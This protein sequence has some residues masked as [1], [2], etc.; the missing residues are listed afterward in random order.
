MRKTSGLFRTAVIDKVFLFLLLLVASPDGAGALGLLK[1]GLAYGNQVDFVQPTYL[2]NHVTDRNYSHVNVSVNSS[3][4]NLTAFIDWNRSLVGWWAFNGNVSLTQLV[5]DSSTYGNNGTLG[6]NTSVEAADPAWTAAGVFGGALSFDGANRYVNVSKNSS[7][8]I[9]GEITMEAWVYSNGPNWK[10]ILDKNRG[11]AYNIHKVGPDGNLKMEGVFGNVSSLTSNSA[12]LANAWTHV[13]ATYNGSEA[14]LYINGTLEGRV[15]GNGGA[16]GASTD[17]IRIGQFHDEIGA[18]DGKLDEVRLWKRALSEQEIRASYNASRYGLERNFTG[19]ALGAYTYKAYSQNATGHVNDTGLRTL[20][21]VADA[22]PPVIYAGSPANQS[23]S[24]QSI[25]F[26]LT[27]NENASWCGVSIDTGSNRTMVNSSGNWNIL[28]SSVPDG[29]RSALF[30]CNDTA[31]NFN[32]SAMVYFTVSTATT[33]TPTP[34]SAPTAIASGGGG[35]GGGGTSVMGGI[36]T[37]Q[38]GTLPAGGTAKFTIQKQASL[39]VTEVTIDAKKAIMDGAKITIERFDGRPSAISSDP[40]TGAA[41]GYIG[42]SLSNNANESVSK[43]VIGFRVEKSWI[44]NGNYS[45]VGLYRWHVGG[46]HELPT[47]LVAEDET[48]N[49]YNAETPGLS[50]FAVTGIISARPKATPTPALS[51]RMPTKTPAPKP[52]EEPR[53]ITTPNTAINVTRVLTNVTKAAREYIK[54]VEQKVNPAG[55][56]ITVVL[57]SSLL[58]LAINSALPPSKIYQ[59]LA[60]GMVMGGVMLW[61]LAFRPA[62]PIKSLIAAGALSIIVIAY[63]ILARGGR[64]S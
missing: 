15:A 62:V 53:Q 64:E 63:I 30:H 38:I 26:N 19:L 47:R 56:A 8:D 17:D 16:I 28:N 12:I 21:V 20:N 6:R 41:Y 36:E 60:V 37:Y 7:L 13:A 22:T 2:D 35:G 58:W 14:R 51:V 43:A 25:W 50:F 10:A 39:G 9:T 57:L 44:S 11:S 40:E 3:G 31:G 52:T 32:S 61:L 48:Y 24:S 54:T 55:L 23:Y 33:P 49:Y 34:T 45:G 5:N 46:W 29:L 27:L 42:I 1:I 4:L 59:H 18:W